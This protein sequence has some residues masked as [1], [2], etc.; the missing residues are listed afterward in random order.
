MIYYIYITYLHIFKQF[1]I[2]IINHNNFYYYN[3][4]IY[5]LDIIIFKF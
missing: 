3:I 1:F 2:L 4:I 5:K